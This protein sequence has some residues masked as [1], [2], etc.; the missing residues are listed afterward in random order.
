MVKGVRGEKN[1][2]EEGTRRKI[3]GKLKLKGKIFTNW[4]KLKV[5]EE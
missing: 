1:A 2:K 3:K 4:D 5:H